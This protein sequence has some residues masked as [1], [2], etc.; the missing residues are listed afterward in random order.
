MNEQLEEPGPPSALIAIGGSAGAFDGLIQLLPALPETLTA[1]VVIVIHV[2]AERNTGLAQV[3]GG[4]SRLRVCEAEDKM[5]MRAGVI[6]VAPPDYH[7]L[8]EADGSLALSA[9][10]PVHFSRPSIDVLFQSAAHAFG[11]R[12]LGILLSGASADGADG[13][14]A[15]RARG[16]VTWVQR[17][18]SA[19]APVMPE[20][21][22][23]RA[24]HRSMDVGDMA[25][26]L[27]EWG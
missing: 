12:A 25:R 22:L 15:I 24:A 18:E 11:K 2:P 4:S 8:V 26:V 23:A 3:P 6:Y 9:D 1:A 17:P 7:L 16:G 20:A 10:E 19:A 21:A 27:G 14:A 13:L 5:P